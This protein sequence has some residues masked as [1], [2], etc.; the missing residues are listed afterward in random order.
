MFDAGSSRGA[1]QTVVLAAVTVGMALVGLIASAGFVVL[2]QRR[3][4]QLG[5]VAAIGASPRPVRTVVVAGGALIGATSAVAG[6]VVGLGTWVLAAPAVERAADRRPARTDVPW[7]LVLGAAA[8]TVGTALV[9]AWWVAPSA[10][11]RRG[12]GAATQ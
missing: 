4:R 6:L 7:A 5:P 2:A 8:I 1:A 10:A 3:Q 12:T 11:R 9:A